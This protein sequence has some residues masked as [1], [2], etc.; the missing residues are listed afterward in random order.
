VLREAPGK[1]RTGFILR[2]FIL[3]D[4]SAGATEPISEAEM[5]SVSAAAG[6]A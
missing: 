5:A 3:K 6:P 4:K 1:S 2:G